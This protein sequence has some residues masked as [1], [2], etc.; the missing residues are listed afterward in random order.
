[1]FISSHLLDEIEKTC[2]AAA[3]IDR[4]RIIAQAPMRELTGGASLEDRFLRLTSRV[5]DR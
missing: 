4:G 1:V 5:G 2:D 3:V